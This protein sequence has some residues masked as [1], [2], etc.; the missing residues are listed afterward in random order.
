MPENGFIKD[1]KTVFQ[2]QVVGGIMQS[3]HLYW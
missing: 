1:R 2:S 3:R